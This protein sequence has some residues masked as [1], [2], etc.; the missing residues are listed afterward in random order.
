MNEKQMVWHAYRAGSLCQLVDLEAR[1]EEIE[2]IKPEH[3]LPTRRRLM[4]P[5][6]GQLPEEFVVACRAWDEACRA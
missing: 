6:I 4:K 1:R 3:E 5:V 2:R